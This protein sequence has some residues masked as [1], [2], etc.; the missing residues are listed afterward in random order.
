ML[1]AV[2]H[3]EQVSARQN[4]A[5]VSIYGGLHRKIKRVKS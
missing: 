2:I 4:E 3:P 5:E 1:W